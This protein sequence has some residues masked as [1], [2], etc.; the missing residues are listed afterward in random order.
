MFDTFISCKIKKYVCQSTSIYAANT[1]FINAG[2]TYRN[3]CRTLPPPTPIR[4]AID[5]SSFKYMEGQPVIIEVDNNLS[6]ISGFDFSYEVMT[7]SFS[8][9][10][11]FFFLLF[12]YIWLV[13]VSRHYL[14]VEE[15]ICGKIFVVSPLYT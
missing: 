8:I 2:C 12:L 6:S 4:L 11:F 7:S 3:L 1:D 5:I 13:A 14:D 15:V 9:S 10:L